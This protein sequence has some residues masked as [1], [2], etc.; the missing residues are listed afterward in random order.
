MTSFSSWSKVAGWLNAFK[1][2]ESS[3]SPDGEMRGP[4]T[5]QPAPCPNTQARAVRS[6]LLPSVTCKESQSLKKGSG[7]ADCQ[8]PQ[9]ETSLRRGH[10]SLDVD[11]GRCC[12]IACA[13]VKN[14]TRREMDQQYSGNHVHTEMSSSE[15]HSHKTSFNKVF[16]GKC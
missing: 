11:E 9:M 16:P 4:C 5:L 13:S 10:L 6:S 15:P 2:I 1:D 7:V 3:V 12:T 14:H 8:F